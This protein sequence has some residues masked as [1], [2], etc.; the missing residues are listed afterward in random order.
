M[1]SFYPYWYRTDLNFF[2]YYTQ[3]ALGPES[4]PLAAFNKLIFRL[5]LTQFTLVSPDNSSSDLFLLQ[6]QR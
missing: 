3:G 2:D 4:R 1:Y 6:V 5:P